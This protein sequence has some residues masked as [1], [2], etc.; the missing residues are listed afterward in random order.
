M[1]TAYN[2]GLN[3]AVP[4]LLIRSLNFVGIKNIF[5]PKITLL[6]STCIKKQ[7]QD[8][9]F[10]SNGIYYKNEYYIIMLSMVFIVAS[11]I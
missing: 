6:F 5:R 8:L 9:A 3:L 7:L 11:K 4:S 2:H 1:T 10:I